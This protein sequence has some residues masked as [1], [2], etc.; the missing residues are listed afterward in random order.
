MLRTKILA[1]VTV[2]CMAGCGLSFYFKAPL[3]VRA[4]ITMASAVASRPKAPSPLPN[5]TNWINTETKKIS[6]EA[7]NLNPAV[8]RLSL[9][10]YL[11]A[12][13]QGLDQKKVLTIVDYSKPSGMRR[14][15]VID[16]KSDKI[17]F[18]TWVA[19]GKNSGGAVATSFSNKN[20]SLK[21]SLGVFD[22]AEPYTGHDGYSL[23][24][25]GLEQGVNDNAYNRDVVFHGAAYASGAV[26]KSRG[27]LGRSWGCLAVGKETIT[28]LVNTIKNDTIVVA[29]Y[30]DKTWLEK[31][32]YLNSKSI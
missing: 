28:P 12:R 23:R 26:A 21:S 14:L 18:N 22:T 19:H 4:P 27:M 24:V 1:V 29:Y 8:L 32:P 25:R 31:S 30:P 11:H 3:N 10:A 13:K 7:N 17:L 9:V 15:W 20:Q 16:L 2:L 6:S 5:T